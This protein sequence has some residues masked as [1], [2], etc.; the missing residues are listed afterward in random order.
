MRRGPN[1]KPFLIMMI[2]TLVASSGLAYMQYGKYGEAKAEVDR[3]QKEQLNENEVKAKLEEAVA[4]LNASKV[5]LSHLEQGV[6]EVAYVPTLLKELERTGKEAGLDVTGVRPVP[7]AVAA[8]TTKSKGEQGRKAKKPDYTELDIQVAARGDYRSVM[9]FVKAMTMFPKILAA[10]TVSIQPNSASLTKMSAAASPVL[11]VTLD[12]RAY[13][14]PSDGSTK[15]TEA[16]EAPTEKV[17]N[18]SGRNKGIN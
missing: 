1:P 13:L 18:I 2:G 3:L 12:F 10:R 11:D 4:K 15:K 16:E 14:F 6:P 7:R 5:Q 9:N 8:P 17:I